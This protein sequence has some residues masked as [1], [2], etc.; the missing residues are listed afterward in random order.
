MNKQKDDINLPGFR[1]SR[2]LDTAIIPP[3][4]P[5]GISLVNFTENNALQAY[6]L[7]QLPDQDTANDKTT[8][9]DWWTALT[10]D[11]EYDPSLCFLIYDEIGLVGFA[12]CWTS[13]FIKDLV[14]H[15]RRRRQGLGA[16]L[17]THVFS[18]FQKL[19]ANAVDLKVL[20]S[21]SG[22]IQLYTSSGMQIIEDLY[23]YRN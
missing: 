15:P 8:F 12:Q 2:K 22:A 23:T 7:L 21:N 9:I 13:A 4:W 10:S 1:M 5:G 6:Q 14:I 11:G 3:V 18:V 16:L 19:Q 17:L 20:K